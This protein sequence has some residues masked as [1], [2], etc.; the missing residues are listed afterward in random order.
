[1][2]H[3]LNNQLRKSFRNIVLSFLQR[4]ESFLQVAEPFLNVAES[5][6]IPAAPFYAEMNLFKYH[7]LFCI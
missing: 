4:A 6:L 2:M 7:S 1:M 5:F 3:Y